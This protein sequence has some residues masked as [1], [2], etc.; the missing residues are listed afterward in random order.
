MPGF[1]G[2]LILSKQTFS[3]PHRNCSYKTR[4]ATA[5]V[6]SLKRTNRKQIYLR[7][8]Y[9]YGIKKRAVPHF[10]SQAMKYIWILYFV[11]AS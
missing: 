4:A 9:I 1:I 10:Y 6:A 7:R 2:H 11:H 3:K 8:P 5:C